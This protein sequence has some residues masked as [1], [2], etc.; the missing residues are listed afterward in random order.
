MRIVRL[1]LMLLLGLCARSSMQAQ[2]KPNAE[3]R[4]LPYVGVV[5]GRAS[6]LPTPTY[7]KVADLNCADGKVEI[8]VIIGKDGRVTEANAVSGDVLLLESS[9]VAAKAAIFRPVSDGPP[10][11][12]RGKLVY[13]F[14]SFSKCANVGIVNEKAESIPKPAIPSGCRCSGLVVVSVVID[15]NGKVISARS[16]A[17]HPLLRQSAEKSALGAKFRPMLIDTGPARVKARLTY[18]FKPSG[19]V[20]Y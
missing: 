12:I 14:D 19:E 4:I 1:L 13:N 5:N 7:G 11:R 2:R 10:V 9:I 16:F 8:E 15:E 20:N 3:T 18:S 6:Y 17:G